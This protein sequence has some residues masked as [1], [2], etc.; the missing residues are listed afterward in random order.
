MM[1]HQQRVV[2]EVASLFSRPHL[3]SNKQARST[4]PVVEAAKATPIPSAPGVLAVVDSYD[5]SH[6][7]SSRVDPMLSCQGNPEYIP[8]SRFLGVEAEPLLET[9]K[10]GPAH[11]ATRPR[12]AKGFC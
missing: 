10:M 1:I 2:P 7:S 4:F 12:Q 6:L 9:G 11:P 8:P 5:C 3:K